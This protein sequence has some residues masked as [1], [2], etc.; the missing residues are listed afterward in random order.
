ML[1]GGAGTFKQTFAVTA[2]AGVVIVLQQLFT[3]PLSYASG[4]FAG[5]NLA[6]FVPM[7]EETSFP[8]RFLGAIDLFLVWW[9]FSL[10]VGVA[11]LYRRRTGPIFTSL[12]GVYIVIALILAFVRSGS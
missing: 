1:M 9:V 5:A 10:A 8:V 4:R 7:L 11:V 12:M 3:I 6:V 2:H